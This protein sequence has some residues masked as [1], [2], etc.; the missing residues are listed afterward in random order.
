MTTTVPHQNRR[1][2]QLPVYRASE[3]RVVNGANEGDG[4]SFASELMLDDVYELRQASYP[5]ALAIKPDGENAFQITARSS[6]GRPAAQLYLD[7]CITLMRSSGDTLEALVF[8]EVD[9]LGNVVDIYL[10]ALAALDTKTPYTLVGID[11]ETAHRRL[12]LMNCVSFT[13]GTHITMAN[14]SQTAIENLKVGDRVL[15]RDSGSQEIR[16][17]GRSTVRASGPYAPVVITAGTL[18]NLGDLVVNPDHRLFVYQREDKLEAGQSEIL[19]K[20]RYLLNGDS[21]YTQNGG[22]VE[23]FQLL[24]DDHHIIFAEGIA[25]ETMLVD[26]KTHSVLPGALSK[27]FKNSQPGLGNPDKVAVEVNERLLLTEN[28]AKLLRRAS[29]R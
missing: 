25:A 1:D 17:I 6:V 5:A 11:Q 2:Q 8:V 19:V 24:F 12:A 27:K 10:H 7:C 26:D 21:I 15:T 20:A 28:A 16:W 18:N 9:A 3:F 23:Y 4:L 22:F 14:G 13:R 29:T